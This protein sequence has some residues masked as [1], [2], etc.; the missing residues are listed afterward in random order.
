MIWAK[1]SLQKEK[2]IS[3]TS[4]KLVQSL[5]CKDPM[6]RM[7]RQAAGWEKTFAKQ[8][9]DKRLLSRIYKELPKLK[10]KKKGIQSS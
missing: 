10:I 8:I 3:W 6:K 5:L 2:L 4:P 9:S 1:H 7:K